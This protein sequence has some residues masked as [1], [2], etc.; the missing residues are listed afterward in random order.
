MDSPSRNSIP[1]SPAGTRKTVACRTSEKVFVHVTINTM[2]S[3]RI[4]DKRPAR[5]TAGYHV[6][7]E[8]SRVHI[9]THGWDAC[10]N[11]KHEYQKSETHYKLI[12]AETA[13]PK[14]I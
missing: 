1:G 7:S 14:K 6:L 4:N 11:E 2:M 10:Y 12:E 13:G 3:A 5:L 8:E 9:R